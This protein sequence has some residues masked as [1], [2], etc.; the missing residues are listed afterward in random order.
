MIKDR[1]SMQRLTNILLVNSLLLILATQ[2]LAQ[3]NLEQNN[4]SWQMKQ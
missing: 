4:K 1:S 2:V 3:E